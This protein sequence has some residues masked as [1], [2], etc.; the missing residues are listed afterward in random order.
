MARTLTAVRVIQLLGPLLRLDRK[1]ALTPMAEL[2]ADLAMDS[3]DRQTLA[4]DL[5]ESFRIEIPDDDLAGWQTVLD[6]AETVDRLLAAK[7]E[8]V[9]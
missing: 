2:E 7:L 6:I 4:C 8:Q 1:Q 5:D 9:A 3:L